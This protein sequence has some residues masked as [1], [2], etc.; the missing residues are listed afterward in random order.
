MSFAFCFNNREAADIRPWNG[1]LLTENGASYDKVHLKEIGLP[2]LDA[3]LGGKYYFFLN[4]V[5]ARDTI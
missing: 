4:E 5:T 3:I 2:N 1:L